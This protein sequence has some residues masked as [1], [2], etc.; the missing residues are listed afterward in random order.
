MV[1]TLAVGLGA[2]A[3]SVSYQSTVLF[4][5]SYIIRDSFSMTM[6]SSE[7]TLRTIAVSSVIDSSK[8]V[9][10]C[11]VM[12]HNSRGLIILDPRMRTRWHV[13]YVWKETARHGSWPKRHAGK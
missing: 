8:K 5:Q 3:C 1:G 7:A 12:P 11:V 13:P 9:E 6:I 2:V 4:V 10:A